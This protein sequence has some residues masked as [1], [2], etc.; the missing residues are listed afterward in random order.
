MKTQKCI[1]DAD[2]G[3][4]LEGDL[5]EQQRKTLQQH[6]DI[7][8]DCRAH[9]QQASAGSKYIKDM[10]S[11]AWQ[12]QCLSEDLISGFVNGTMNLEKDCPGSYCSMPTM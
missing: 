12:S 4:L 10:F 7:C 1:S 8:P 6:I 9:W 2:I 5:S 11:A 3:C